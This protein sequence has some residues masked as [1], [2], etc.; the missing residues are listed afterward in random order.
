MLLDLTRTAWRYELGY[1]SEQE[2]GAVV[3]AE[4][5]R[6][7]EEVVSNAKSTMGLIHRPSELIRVCDEG[8][9]AAI[10]HK[11]RNQFK[12]AVVEIKKVQNALEVIRRFSAAHEE[13]ESARSAYRRIESLLESEYLLQGTSIKVLSGLLSEMDGLLKKAEYRQAHII[14]RMCKQRSFALETVESQCEAK[15][16]GLLQRVERI[17][18]I[19]DQSNPF[20]AGS[21]S[22]IKRAGE[23]I[24]S[25]IEQGYLV[26]ARRLIEDIEIDIAPR[27]TL[28]AEYGRHARIFAAQTGEQV[29]SVEHLKSMC[30][31]T[32]WIAATDFLLE[33]ALNALS[34]DLERLDKYIARI[35]TAP[36]PPSSS[37][38]ERPE[39]GGTF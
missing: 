22:T 24:R 33:T 7:V 36:V 31:Q 9:N 25:I 8:I 1:L 5:N 6:L 27:R 29:I 39:K 32:S 12:E 35:T 19:C 2:A 23:A 20:T 21:D 16:G 18:E 3:E 13:Y 11:R 38:I 4:V 30:V 17:C 34:S 14:G 10:G 37:E 28:V 15:S 26:L